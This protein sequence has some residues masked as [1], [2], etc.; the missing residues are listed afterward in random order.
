MEADK[1]NGSVGGGQGLSPDTAS[2]VGRRC[3]S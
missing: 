3:G 1:P 2:D